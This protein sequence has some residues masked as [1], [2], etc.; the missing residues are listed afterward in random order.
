MVSKQPFVAPSRSDLLKPILPSGAVALRPS[1]GKNAYFIPT[2]TLDCR[3]VGQVF[4]EHTSDSSDRGQDI[5][6]IEANGK[7][8]KFWE[9]VV[10][11]TFA[12]DLL[13]TMI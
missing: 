4:F 12:M 13:L 9:S 2:L 11:Q 7:Q 8:T 6:E 1:Y 5:F 3:L 10:F